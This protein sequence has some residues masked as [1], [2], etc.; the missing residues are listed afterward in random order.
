VLYILRLYIFVAVQN[1][2]MALT[3]GALSMYI[4]SACIQYD[5]WTF[6]AIVVVGSCKAAVGGCYCYIEL[7]ASSGR[8]SIQVHHALD[9]SV[10]PP[11]CYTSCQPNN[12]TQLE[13]C[14]LCS[15]VDGSLHGVKLMPLIYFQALGSC[16]TVSL[17]LDEILLLLNLLLCSCKM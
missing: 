7:T 13:P 16:V 14:V 17:I 9:Q 8:L 2:Q 3:H 4:C 6:V 5:S 1:M 11:P 10:L 12:G 15:K